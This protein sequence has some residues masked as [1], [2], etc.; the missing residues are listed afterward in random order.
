AD[1]L[2]TVLDRSQA[3]R[4]RL[5]DF[6]PF[7]E[8]GKPATDRARGEDKRLTRVPGIYEL[9]LKMELTYAGEAD[10]AKKVDVGI[11]YN[12]VNQGFKPLLLQY[13]QGRLR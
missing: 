2:E 9:R 12:V 10:T 4:S 7:A 11:R 1:K 3:G 6:F 8:R 5:T 13:E